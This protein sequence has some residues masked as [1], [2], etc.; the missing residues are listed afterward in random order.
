MRFLST[1]V[2]STLGVFVA[3]GILFVFL[4][5]FFIALAS[6]ADQAPSVR[7]GSALVINLRGPIP[8]SAPN[9]PL[10]Q[11]FGGGADFDLRDLQL[12]L[13]K[14]AVDDRIDAVWLQVTGVGGAWATLEEI[15]RAL[16]AF[17]TESGKPVIASSDDFTIS[18]A[19]YFIA[20]AADSVFAQREGIF[21]YN[22]FALI[23][24]FFRGTLDRLEIEPQVVRAGSFKSAAE[25]FTRTG[26]SPENREQLYAILGDINSRF[27]E[28]VAESR[29]LTVDALQDLV[30]GGAIFSAEEAEAAGLLDALLYHDEVVDLL[31]DRIGDYDEEDDLRTISLGDYARVPASDAGLELGDEGEVAIVYAVGP[32][33][34]GDGGERD[35]FSSGQQLAPLPFRDAI[36]TARED[37]DVKAVVVRVNSPGGSASASEAI[38]REVALTREEKPVVIS[39]GDYAASGGYWISTP[40]ETI[41]ADPLTL[42]G[43]IGVFFLGFNAREFFNDKLG[44]T[45]DGV[46]T[47]PYA[48]MFYGIDGF[49]EG[50]REVAERFVQDTYATF[51]EKVAQ[52]RDLAIEQ[53]D[54]I[55]QGRVWTGIQAQKLGL[56]DVLG[57][58]DDAVAIAAERAGLEEGTYRT[59][60]L[61]RPKTFIER[62]ARALETRAAQAWLHLTTT[63]SERFLLEQTRMLREVERMHGTVQ[64]RMLLDVQVH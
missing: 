25:P 14:A 18:E 22:G 37:D 34:N 38:W 23:Q 8:E 60:I 32:I 46:Q 52:S 40:A 49:E 55:A 53:V 12:G 15:R 11:A 50:E 43:S 17:K 9:D 5:L 61:P 36:K 28:A 54:A 16:E 26:L 27:L 4:L 3:I 64:A 33:V 39:M 21:E 41:V 44:V 56:V 51:L 35:P 42:T 6:S 10:T 24:P 29:G 45:F 30:T 62:F 31:K 13:R 63:P 19:G 7:S 47:S 57:G 48:D 1:L 2:A 58:L 20:S 59:R